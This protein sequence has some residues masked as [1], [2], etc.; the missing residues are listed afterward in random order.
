MN[1]PNPRFILPSLLFLFLALALACS[2]SPTSLLSSK[3]AGLQLEP[4][5]ADGTVAGSYQYSN[6]AGKQTLQFSV[7]AD[8]LASFRLEDAPESEVLIVNSKPDQLPH[9]IWQGQDV[10]GL[11]A[12]SSE[13]QAALVDLLKGDLAHGLALIPMDM[14]CQGADAV[15]PAQVAALLFPLQ[16]RFKYFTADRSALAA[17]LTALAD[18]NYNLEDEGEPAQ[19]PPVIL[20]TPADP[21]PVVLGYFPF[22]E[23][24]ALEA[25]A[26]GAGVKLASFGHSLQVDFSII[27]SIHPFGPD[28]IQNEWGPCE[29]KCRGACGP[30]CTHNNCKFYIDDRCEKNQDGENDGTASLVQVY[31]CGTH[32]ACI[33]HDACY[34]DCNRRHGCG[35]FAAAVC[36]HAGVLDPTTAM[37]ALFGLN[38]SCD[39]K[40]LNTYP[41]GD[42]EDWYL[43]YGPQPN[44]QTYEY[45]LKEYR[46]VED[47]I[48]CPKKQA[49]EPIIPPEEE[50]EPMADVPVV[51]NPVSKFKGETG[52]RLVYDPIEIRE[53]QFEITVDNEGSLSGLFTFDYI[54][55]VNE[56]VLDDGDVCTTQY[57]F[58]TTITISG[59]LVDNKGTVT[60][61]FVPTICEHIGTCSANI[62]CPG[63]QSEVYIEIINDKLDGQW[64]FDEFP[65]FTVPFSGTKQ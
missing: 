22:D 32:Q 52:M 62:G 12:L 19:N 63:G 23:V 28:P 24:G 1:K 20:M 14:A 5:A 2:F 49:E 65:D 42:V 40:V 3:P 57:H 26:T 46:Y 39:R 33:E 15:T 60:A 34:D 58:A 10:D 48:N 7:S 43:G 18:C 53:D 9:L 47:P 8:G 29:A 21:V 45:H 37:A 16:M 38:I 4:R 44:M 17:G 11:G 27:P 55:N 61:D 64:M 59:Q 41:Y 56:H 50:V 36:R 54:T 25:A 35:T 13:E 6:G 31:E 51:P 30:D